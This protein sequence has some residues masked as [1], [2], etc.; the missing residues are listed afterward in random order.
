VILSVSAPRGQRVAL[1]DRHEGKHAS[2][3]SGFSGVQESFAALNAK[4]YISAA[5]VAAVEQA[6]RSEQRKP[7]PYAPRCAAS[8]EQ[9]CLKPLRAADARGA[10]AP[11]HYE[12]NKPQ[13]HIMVVSTADW[14]GPPAGC[15][16]LQGIGIAHAQ[17]V[18]MSAFVAR[19]R[20]AGL[21]C[22]GSWCVCPGHFKAGCWCTPATVCHELYDSD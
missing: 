2:R 15:Q 6:G 20:R 13:G 19:M 18:C 17:D 14:F 16:G 10:Q 4:P 11:A 9:P 3:F 5:R 21:A 1:I 12:G 22:S 8:P 7:P